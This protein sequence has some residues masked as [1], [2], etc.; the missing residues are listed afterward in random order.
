MAA[1]DVSAMQAAASDGEALLETER[2]HAAA[3][4]RRRAVLGGLASLG[5][6]I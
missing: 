5:Y 1:P 2:R 4:A 3:A 6:E